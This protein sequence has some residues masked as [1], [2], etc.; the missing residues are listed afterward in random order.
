MTPHDSVSRTRPLVVWAVAVLAAALSGL[1]VGVHA[2]SGGEDPGD[3]FNSSWG[4]V[5]PVGDLATGSLGV[6]ERS[7]WRRPLLLAWFRF[8]ELPF[9]P[10]GADAFTYREL[11]TTTDTRASVAAWR[12]AVK[13]A[14]PDLEPDKEPS[15][16]SDLPGVTWGFFENCPAGSWDQARRTL[17]ARR[18]VW[19][20]ESAALR[21]WI[22]AQHRVF[23]RCGLGPEQFRS[24]LPAAS[25][26][27]E[28]RER[29][30]MLPEM[31]LSDPPAGAPRL[32]VKDRDYQRACALFY[33]GQ[34][35][36]AERAFTTIA[37]DS[38][39]PWQAWGRYLALRAR[40]R[41]FQVI[42][43]ALAPQ[44]N[45]A[46]NLRHDV[47]T[48]LADARR[49]HASA[50]AARLEA[51][52]GLVGA[53]LDPVGRFRELGAL[54]S[55]P[56]SKAH[57]FRNAVVDYLHLHRQLPPTEPLGEWLAG[58]IDARDP[59]SRTCRGRA[60]PSPTSRND[61]T[62]ADTRCLRAQ[63]SQ[64]A[65]A[66]YRQRPSERAWLFTAVTFAERTDPHRE[67]LIAALAE[68]PPAHPGSTTFLLHRLRLSG[69]EDGHRLAEELLA[70]PE[71]AAD[72]SARNRVRQYRLLSATRLDEFWSDALRERGA[73]FDR[74]T[75]L[76]GPS[77]LAQTTLG[78]D[79]D[80]TWILDYELPHA[81]LLA[82][83]TQS[84]WPGTSP[85]PGGRHGLGPRRAAPRH[86][87][88]A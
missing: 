36:D 44:Q 58:L 75:L 30:F 41:E 74:D 76:K 43:G 19:G 9:P 29:R 62:P 85:A 34:Y 27:R 16:E 82:T 22:V 50:E 70:R 31:S 2:S 66:R 61:Q 49:R 48:A 88:G 86:S 7:W 71:M 42:P 38:R 78:W 45:S 69:R 52:Q 59:A 28:A 8:N 87:V 56:Q 5:R 68:V 79:A 18:Q 20:A 24:D 64:K 14:A 54:L 15:A 83:V 10:K 35:A 4:P 65:F 63:L 25:R 72:Y 39:S 37:R 51:L 11:G 3:P 80:A 46:S 12:Q 13:R 73:G 21:D 17:V 6:V 40:F 57:I 84:A 60:S 1:T 81:A 23:A 77:E 32:L 55:R 67:A 53:R 26:F 47:D 33:E